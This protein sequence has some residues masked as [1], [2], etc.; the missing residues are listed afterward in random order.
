[1]SSL[2]KFCSTWPVT[3]VLLAGMAD[4]DPHPAII[5]PQRG[6]DGAQ[7]VLPGIAAAGLHFDLAGGQVDL[8]MRPPPAPTAA[9]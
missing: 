7:A 1:M 8:V 3:A 2:E 4:A 9:A 5:R 6:G